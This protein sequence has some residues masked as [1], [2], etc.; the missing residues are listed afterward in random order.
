MRCLPA[1]LMMM[2]LSAMG[3][4]N[5]AADPA[6]VSLV[7]FRI[8][9]QFDK[10]HT[11]GYYRHSVVVLVTGDRKG[12]DYIEQWAAA[13]HDSVVGLVDSYRVKFLPAAHLKGVPFFIKSTI[14]SK[15][16]KEKEKWTLMDYGGV[17][18]K[19]YDLPDDMCSVV[20]FD[21]RGI[22][23]LQKSVTDFEPIVQ[24][25]LLAE[26]RRLARP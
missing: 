16:P 5:A 1:I 14:K 3:P 19:A 4:T 13:L 24:A 15:F 18:K 9:D 7:D 26:I 17:F 21:R 22:R 25:E 8:K 11:A 12:S 23:R 10:L 20:V 2:C 6:P